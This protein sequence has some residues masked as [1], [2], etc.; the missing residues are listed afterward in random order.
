MA[1]IE[2]PVNI[3]SSTV[4]FE[5]ASVNLCDTQV[6]QPVCNKHFF[7]NLPP[8]KI[9]LIRKEIMDASAVYFYG[10]I[11]S[12]YEEAVVSLPGMYSAEM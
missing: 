12:S 7:C 5:K 9:K 2:F 10:I 8:R 4:A 3:T 6:V 11:S 1:P